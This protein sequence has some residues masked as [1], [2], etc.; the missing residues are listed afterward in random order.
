MNA[1]EDYEE[2]AAE[3]KAKCE[4][5]SDSI[6]WNFD[7]HLIEMMIGYFEWSL[8]NAMGYPGHLTAEEWDGMKERHLATL[9]GF[10]TREEG[11]IWK[12]HSDY[13][14]K[15]LKDHGGDVLS[16]VNDPVKYPH[17]DEYKQAEEDA[18]KAVQ[19]VFHW[20]ADHLFHLWD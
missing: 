19:D 3:W 14:E 8:K 16:A 4:A 13:F 9:K 15:K 12:D 6:Y 18:H 11:G 1:E 7:S 10:V 5:N 17:W 2:I 20:T